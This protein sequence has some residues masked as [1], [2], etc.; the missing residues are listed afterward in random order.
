MADFRAEW[1]AKLGLK[2]GIPD[3]RGGA[4]DAH[5]DAVG[6]GCREGDVVNV[7]G[8]STCVI[9][10]M[11]DR[12]VI[13]GVSGVVPGS[14]DPSQTGV[15]AGI[16]AVGDMFDAIARRAGTT[17]REL[18]GRLDGVSRGADGAAAAVLG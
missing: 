4:L 17:V 14:V 2:A 8:T 6:A 7:V 5:W 16:P 13:P 18:A 10:V 12:H 15:E 9:A 3:S 11:G 1:A